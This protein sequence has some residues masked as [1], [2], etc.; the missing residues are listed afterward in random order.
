MNGLIALLGS[1]E[2]LSVMDDVDAYLLANCG[3]NGRKPRVVCLPTAAGRE[4]DASVTRWSR[5]GVEHFTRLGA[6]VRA[7]PVID[8]DSANEQNHASAVEE[9]DV[10]YFSGG[11]PAYLHQTMKDSLVW[12][13]ALKVWERGGV[14]AGCSAGAMILAKEIPDFRAMGLR[15]ISAFGLIP[16]AFVMPHFDAIPLFGKPLV[17]TLRKRLSEDEVMIGVDEN[18]AVVGKLNEE[19]TVLGEASAHIFTRDENK[20]YAAGEKFSLGK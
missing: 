18:T 17:A 11:S 9:A 13:S 19:W 15:S 12:K 3:A 7:V 14:Y 8:A 10:V 4:G 5:M 20:S 2:Y 16:A 6:D 1:G